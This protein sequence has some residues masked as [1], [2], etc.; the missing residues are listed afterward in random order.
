MLT[1]QV[2]AASAAMVKSA[3]VGG[4]SSASL[5]L[6]ESKGRVPESRIAALSIFT[7]GFVGI[8]GMFGINAKKQTA[9]SAAKFARTAAASAVLAAML[10]TASCAGTA[11]EKEP[12]PPQ[13][14]MYTITV[15]ASATN[16]PTHMQSFTLTVT[17]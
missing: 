15:T 3:D 9:V 10:V 14:K 13:A 6:T 11:T 7:L 5:S 17:P 16:G 2:P 1:I 4:A 12:P 8:F